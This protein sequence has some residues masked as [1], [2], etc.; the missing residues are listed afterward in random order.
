MRKMLPKEIREGQMFENTRG[1][2][3]KVK[4]VTQNFVHVLFKNEVCPAGTVIVFEKDE[5]CSF[6]CNGGFIL[7][8]NL[9]GEP[10]K[11]TKAEVDER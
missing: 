7:K 4:E 10:L 2:W 6:L 11:I 5:F 9:S 1:E 3:V 8:E